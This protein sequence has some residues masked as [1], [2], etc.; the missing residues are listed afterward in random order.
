MPARV[1]SSKK[2][3]AF[4]APPRALRAAP[5]RP[6]ATASILGL[7][8]TAAGKP[9]RRLIRN[10]TIWYMDARSAGGTVA[11]PEVVWSVLSAVEDWPRWMPT[12]TAVER[13]QARGEG[14]HCGG[15]IG[16]GSTFEVAQPRLGRGLWVVTEWVPGLS[17]TWVSL[18]PGVRTT[19]T[20][21]IG[22]EE[23]GTGIELG[24]TWEGPGAWFVRAMF[25][26]MTQHYTDLE[27]SSLVAAAEAK[28][29]A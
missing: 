6:T 26:R 8:S 1:P 20:H 18:R 4:A 25:G 21:R 7:R 22:A 29:S 12:V 3:R 17:F 19:A 24:I 10:C 2:I 5:S 11:G 28:A 23:G 9:L 14:P 16:V 13:V 27:L 15:G